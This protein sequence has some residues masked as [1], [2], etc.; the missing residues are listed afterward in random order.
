MALA[1][2]YS[3]VV[4]V[5]LVTLLVSCSVLALSLIHIYPNHI[6]VDIGCGMLC[7][8]IENAITKDSFPDINH[9]IRSTIPMLSLIHISSLLRPRIPV[10]RS[11]LRLSALALL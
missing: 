6:G 2:A 5:Q 7:V 10:G 4:R 1:P 3:L 11:R 9:A 8:E